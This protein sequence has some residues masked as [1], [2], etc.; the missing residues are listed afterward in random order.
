M[1][2][3]T[4][5]VTASPCV[6]NCCLDAKDVCLGCFRAMSEILGWH[7]AT[8]CEKREILR[9]CSVR[10]AQHKELFGGDR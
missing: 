8:E 2:N 1:E 9:R 6:R 10:R 5:E 4:P 3:K 7:G